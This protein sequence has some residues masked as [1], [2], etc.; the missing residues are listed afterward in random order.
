MT[1]R[2]LAD[3][4]PYPGKAIL[5]LMVV[6][7]AALSMPALAQQ[8]YDDFVFAVSNDRVDQ[9]KSLLA[10]GI[11]ANT[12]A[13]NGDPV[14]LIAARAGYAATLDALLATRTAKVD[15]RNGFGDTPLMVASISGH[16]AIVK[17]LRARGAEINLT[18]WPPLIYAAT[19]GHDDVVRYLLAEGADINAASPNG[20]TALMMAVRENRASTL[21]LLLEK[22]ANPKLR[23]QDGASALDWAKRNEDRAMIEQLK[24]AGAGD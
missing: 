5:V 10:R 6:A 16:L 19:G 21:E 17:K 3:R 7:A 14:L 23:N 18:G 22:G 12:V 11:D 24:R 2:L 8:L 13:P 20:T 1:T 15:A 4:S 9:V